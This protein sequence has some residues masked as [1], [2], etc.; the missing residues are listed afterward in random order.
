MIIASNVGSISL[1]NNLYNTTNKLKESSRKLSTGKQISKATDNPSGL[2]IAQKMKSQNSGLEQAKRNTQDAVSLLQVAEG[3]LKGVHKALRR[4]RDLAVQASNGTLQS[5][6]RQALDKEVQDLLNEIDNIAQETEF[7][8]KKLLNGNYDTN[9]LSFQIG[10]NTNQKVEI[11]ISDM[12]ASNLGLSIGVDTKSNSEAAIQKIDQAINKVSSERTKLGSFQTSLSHK[13]D[14]LSTTNTN[15]SASEGRIADTDMA[16]E[17]SKY[18]KNK[19]LLKF[20][21]AMTSQIDKK[22]ADV[23]SLLE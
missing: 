22:A 15:L 13:L 9:G 18:T 11:K 20:N 3:G 17:K 8:G 16:A 1:R 12:S 2:A 23:L 5:E 19:I 14:S 21:S 4:M 10:A 7:N 6:E